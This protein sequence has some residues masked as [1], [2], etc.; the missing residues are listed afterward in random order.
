VNDFSVGL[1]LGRAVFDGEQAAYPGTT[2][3]AIKIAWF[4]LYVFG[5][6]GDL[7]SVRTMDDSHGKWAEICWPPA[8]LEP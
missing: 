5:P 7:F 1:W 6:A 8:A 4:S 2:K 3:K